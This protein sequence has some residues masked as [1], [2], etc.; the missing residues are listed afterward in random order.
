MF[1]DP[2]KE[3]DQLQKKLLAEDDANKWLDD[4]LEATRRLLDGEPA[5]PAPN[6]AE[7]IRNFANGYGMADYEDEPEETPEN[8]LSHKRTIRNLVVV[9]L[10]ELAGIVGILG[11]WFIKLL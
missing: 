9:A 4:E 1:D 5:A 10:I 8:E 2:Q 6:A 7:K 3:L 11:Y